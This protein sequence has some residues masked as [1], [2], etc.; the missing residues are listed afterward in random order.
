MQLA[1][2]LHGRVSLLFLFDLGGQHS[3]LADVASWLRELERHTAFLSAVYGPLFASGV[4]SPQMAQQHL[5]RSLHTRES[6]TPDRAFVSFLCIDQAPLWL[7]SLALRSMRHL[8]PSFYPL[9]PFHDFP[10]RLQHLEASR[11]EGRRGGPFPPRA[12]DEED[13]AVRRLAEDYHRLCSLIGSR[14]TAGSLVGS[15]LGYCG[16]WG[17]EETQ[18]FKRKPRDKFVTVLLVDETA[19]VRWHATGAPTEEAVQLLL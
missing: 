3:Q 10:S 7:R 18:A 4:S 17:R 1:S 14:A 9:F 16:K 5:R 19:H 12:P 13:G 15:F 2:R 11:G 6:L 8:S